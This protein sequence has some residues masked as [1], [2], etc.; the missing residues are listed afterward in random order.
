M[1][2]FFRYRIPGTGHT[3]DCGTRCHPHAVYTATET[4]TERGEQEGN[5]EA[6]A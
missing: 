2:R 5:V 1:P 6:R 4:E 3:K